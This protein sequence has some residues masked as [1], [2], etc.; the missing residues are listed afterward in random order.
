M[1]TSLIIALAEITGAMCA[2]PD[3]SPLQDLIET[4]EC[5]HWVDSVYAS[6]DERERV[7]QLVIAH[8]TPEPSAANKATVK[9]LVGKDG[10]GGI[11]F[12]KGSLADYAEMVDLSLIHI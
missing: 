11:L 7:A 5:V 8:I 10:V 6:L 2:V 4:P 9:K 1:M 12:S 3:R